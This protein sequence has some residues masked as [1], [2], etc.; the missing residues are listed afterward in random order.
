MKK[1]SIM[2][3]ACT[4]MLS[5]VAF[6]QKKGELDKPKTSAS[7]PP[8]HT[9]QSDVKLDTF[10]VIVKTFDETESGLKYVAWQ[11]GYVIRTTTFTPQ[12]GN[13]VKDEDKQFLT[14]GAGGVLGYS[15]SEETAYDKS[16]KKVKSKVESVS[17]EDWK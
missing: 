3:L 14:I 8:T 10:K 16:F 5:S 1:Y 15:K 9:A 11:E 13:V 6:S 17:R 4:L 7:P 12:T 2:M